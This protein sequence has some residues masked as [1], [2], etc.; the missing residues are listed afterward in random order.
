[1][2]RL[3]YAAPGAKSQARGTETAGVW[4]DRLRFVG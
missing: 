3:T 1:M 4:Q 2:T